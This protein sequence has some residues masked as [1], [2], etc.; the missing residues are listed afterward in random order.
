MIAILLPIYPESYIAIFLT[1][2]LYCGNAARIVLQISGR[3]HDK[4]LLHSLHWLP[5][6]QR[7]VYKMAV[8][9]FKVH[10]L[11]FPMF[12]QAILL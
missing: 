10:L 6:E 12:V 9:T 11:K 2:F 5:V 7:I 3:S 4:P 1:V 8:V